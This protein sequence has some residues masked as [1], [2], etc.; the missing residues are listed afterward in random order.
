[1]Q[2]LS[3]S[4]MVDGAIEQGAIQSRGDTGVTS[5]VRRDSECAHRGRPGVTPRSPR[6]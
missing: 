3:V 2:I 4:L 1:M 5:G 6:D